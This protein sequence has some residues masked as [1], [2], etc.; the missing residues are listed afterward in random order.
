MTISVLQS[1]QLSAEI[2]AQQSGAWDRYWDL[3]EVICALRRIEGDDT[4]T[5][6]GTGNAIDFL[7]DAEGWPTWDYE[8]GFCH[9]GFLRS[10]DDVLAE[11]QGSITQPLT[12]QG[13]SLGGAR[14]RICV[15]KMVAR[16]WP[17]KRL[18]TFGAPKAGFVN[19]ARIIQKA[20]IEHVSFR[21]RNDPV[22]LVPGL[23]PQW[24]HT[25]PW[26]AM[27]EHASGDDFMPLRDHASA[28]YVAGAK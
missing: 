7:R 4:L 24:E 17:V 28:L 23:L 2:Y 6:M 26:I 12:V 22:P 25:E 9:A 5:F 15:A 21:N 11:A 27:N 19:H 18:C 14:A 16:G 3:G 8:I 13:H 20:G 1:A 10:M